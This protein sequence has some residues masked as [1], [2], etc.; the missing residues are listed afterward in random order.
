[1]GQYD[2][3]S[4]QQAIQLWF[5]QFGKAWEVRVRPE[6]RVRVSP[7]RYRVPDVCVFAR[8]LPT[9][10]VLTHAPVAVFEIMSPEDRLPRMLVKLR[11]YELM[12]VPTIMLI[13]PPTQTISRLV[14][15]A[16]E[17]VTEDVQLLPRSMCSVDWRRVRELL[18]E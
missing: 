11:D 10:Q 18:E 1:M 9:E 6:Y 14:N 7:T 12:G 16:L 13:D 2:H 8:S 3:A 15:G 17:T 5:V 4:W